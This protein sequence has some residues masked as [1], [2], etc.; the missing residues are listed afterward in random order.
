MLKSQKLFHCPI[1]HILLSNLIS[2]NL[3]PINILTDFKHST[4]KT[5]VHWWT[6]SYICQTANS[7]NCT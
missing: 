5:R 2:K 3:L 6:N 1:R 7:T 4:S